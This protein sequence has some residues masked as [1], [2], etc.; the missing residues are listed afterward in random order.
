MKVFFAAILVLGTSAFAGEIRVS[1]V[2]TERDM[3]RSFIL[4]SDYSRQIYLDCQ[5]FVQGLY[6]GPKSEGELIMLDPQ[7]CE[8]LYLR[9]RESVSNGQKHCLEVDTEIT[10]DY[11]C[12]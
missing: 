12:E 4:R 8:D 5:S 11:S 2:T 7:A 1:K 6:L 10:S 3:E 9:I